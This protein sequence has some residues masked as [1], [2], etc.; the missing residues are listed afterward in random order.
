MKTSQPRKPGSLTTREYYAVLIAA[1]FAAGRRD[2]A[3]ALVERGLQKDLIPERFVRELFLHL[4][5]LLGFPSMLDGLSRLRDVS[6]RTVTGRATRREQEGDVV[7]RGNKT[8]RRIYGKATDRLLANLATLHEIVP[9]VIV[10]DA[11]GRI[12]SRPGMSL[13]EREIVNV[14]VLSIQK[15]DRQLYSHLRGALRV[16]VQPRALKECITLGTRAVRSSQ[17]TALNLLSSLLAAGR[18]RR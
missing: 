11:Y 10:R 4:S 18:P 7:R 5:L 8:L 6:D 3:A 13:R 17:D 15:L 9:S 2:E 12:I 16:G 14:V 1:L